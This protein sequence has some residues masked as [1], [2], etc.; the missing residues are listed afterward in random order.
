MIARPVGGRVGGVCL[1]DHC[2]QLGKKK[3]Q[4][5]E[6]EDR[7]IPFVTLSGPLEPSYQYVAP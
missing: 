7:T 3:I 6:K 4:E 1:D 5:V 2:R